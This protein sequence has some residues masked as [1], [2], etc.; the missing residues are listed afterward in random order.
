MEKTEEGRVK[1]RKKSR[2]C[3]VEKYFLPGSECEV[4]PGIVVS[5]PAEATLIEIYLSAGKMNSFKFPLRG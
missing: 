3:K 1:L 4:S 5:L 2:Y